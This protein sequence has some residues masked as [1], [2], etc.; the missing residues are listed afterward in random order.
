MHGRKFLF[1]NTTLQA[2]DIEF[3][4]LKM[5]KFNWFW[6][7][8]KTVFLYSL[9][10]FYFVQNLSVWPLQN[11][12]IAELALKRDKRK[13]W[14]FSFQN[15]SLQFWKWENVVARDVFKGAFLRSPCDLELQKEEFWLLFIFVKKINLWA[16]IC[17]RDSWKYQTWVVLVGE[18]FSKEGFPSLPHFSPSVLYLYFFSPNYSYSFISI[19]HSFIRNY[20]RI[21]FYEVSFKLFIW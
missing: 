8:D 3:A 2:C 21:H 19:N 16:W 13:F 7:R 12:K 4:D 1:K 18:V 17:T 10:F 14:F 9:Y 20:H 5:A 15:V 6:W 11:F